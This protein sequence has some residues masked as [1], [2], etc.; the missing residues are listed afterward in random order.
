MNQSKTTESI[1]RELI[2]RK[3]TDYLRSE[4]QFVGAV[5]DLVEAKE[6]AQLLQHLAEAGGV[7][8]LLDADG[9]SPAMRQS[10]YSRTLDTL[11]AQA[12]ISP[13]DAQKACAIFWRAVYNEDPPVTL[14][15]SSGAAPEPG[16]GKA[17]QFQWK[18]YGLL[19]ALAIAAVCFAIFSV[20]GQSRPASITPPA[21]TTPPSSRPPRMNLEP[22]HLDKSTEEMLQAGTED[23]YTYPDGSYMEFYHDDAGKEIYRLYFDTEKSLT[24]LF[25]A[26]YD[27]RGRLI[28]H[29]SF[30]GAGN[31]LRSDDY[32]FHSS[33]DT[34]QRRIT[35]GSGES[36][37]GTSTFDKEGNEAFTL[38]GMDGSQKVYRYSKDGLIL[39]QE[40]YD[41]DGEIV[42]DVHFSVKI[43]AGSGEKV[44]SNGN[45]VVGYDSYG[46]TIS[47]VQGA[48]GGPLIIYDVS[49]DA[50]FIDR[51]DSMGK[52][53][54]QLYYEDGRLEKLS[55]QEV[56]HYDQQGNYAGQTFTYYGDGGDYDISV[57]DA[58]GHL[59]SSEE[60]HFRD[61]K[62]E[63]TYRRHET[64]L[65]EQGR[66]V[67]VRDFEGRPERL[68][69]VKEYEYDRQGNYQKCTHTLYWED[70]GYRIWISDGEGKYLGS[71][72]YYPSGNI[73]YKKEFNKAGIEVKTT[74]YYE[75]GQ[76]ELL[77]EC[78]ATGKTIRS[79]RYDEEGWKRGVGIYN[80]E[81]QEIS[82]TSY[83]ETG[84]IM[85][86]REYNDQGEKIKDVWYNE[87]GT[88]D[89]NSYT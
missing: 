38:P 39:F 47:F 51:Y 33:E 30:G 14:P 13:E 83:Y 25:A 72:E 20:K 77:C 82:Y 57:T 67:C 28:Q 76:I 19:L 34:A 16:S 53:M 29:Q 84:R 59:T 80:D 26:R 81:G 32:D 79:T 71:L 43:Y 15:V 74:H 61:G 24:Y 54:E 63:V 44:M 3:G 35:L 46:H 41:P 17:R 89:E 66:E 64:D 11:C 73:K 75:D 5:A 49:A 36:F 40:K 69:S 70:G 7:S 65:D 42:E 9:Q 10:I 55:I 87:D 4:Q 52:Q 60:H 45:T 22:F 50:G 6:D 78:N 85:H 12:P 56:Y 58:N 48:C 68:T 88:I 62:E 86:I 8:L 2:R 23:I 27:S 31:L 1:L 21:S 37:Q 18:K